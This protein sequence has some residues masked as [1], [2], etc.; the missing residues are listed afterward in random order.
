MELARLSASCVRNIFA[1]LITLSFL[2]AIA[3][4]ASAQSGWSLCNETSFVLES[5]IGRPEG[6][7]IIV[8]G[9][10]RVRPGECRVA[11]PAPLRPGMHFLF[12]RSSAAHRGGKRIWGGEIP[13]C[14]DSTGS[15]SVESPPSCASMGLESRNFRAVKIDGRTSWTTRFTETEEYTKSQAQAAG[16]Q[17]LLNDAGVSET[18]I[19][20]RPG[21]RTRGVIARFLKANELPANTSDSN[22]ID[23]LEEIARY[24]SRDVGMMVCNRTDNKIWTAIGRR[25][26][27]GWE[28]RGWWMIDAG[29]CAR[30]VDETLIAR[31]H[32]V[33]G[34]METPQGARRLKNATASFC[35]ARSKFAII[36]KEGCAVR[37]YREADFVETAVPTDGKLV[38]EF[39]DR[40]FGPAEEV[41]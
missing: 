9:W 21:R 33:F 36:D 3:P 27:N 22:L 41:R 32:Y 26:G 10:T 31:P 25:R 2:T 6:Q 24:R 39:F 8:E 19:D 15:F 35:M 37:A 18:K 11:L 5:A 38:V 34:E 14:V 13:L 23:I 16:L 1:P 30:T 12:S 40:D 4:S 7:S 20:G 29:A 28:S 17:R